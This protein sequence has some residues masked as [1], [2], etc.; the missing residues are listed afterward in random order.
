MS[1]LGTHIVSATATVFATEVVYSSQREVPLVVTTTDRPSSHLVVDAEVVTKEKHPIYIHAVN[2]GVVNHGDD[3]EE[4]TPRRD[5]GRGEEGAVGASSDG[6]VDEGK[7]QRCPLYNTDR[8]NDT[9]P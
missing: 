7:G 2:C 6:A 4:D 3:G 8:N 9:Y 5:G 1:R